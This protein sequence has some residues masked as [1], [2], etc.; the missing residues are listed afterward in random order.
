MLKTAPCLWLLF[1]SSAVSF[2]TS[3]KR[4]LSES[5]NL[6]PFFLSVC[7]CPG[8]LEP[9]LNRSKFTWKPGSGYIQRKQCVDGARTARW[10][11]R[12]NVCVLFGSEG[13]PVTFKAL[14]VF[15]P[16]LV[17]RHCE[18]TL[19]FIESFWS[20]HVANVTK[21]TFFFLLLSEASLHL[22]PKSHFF[23]T[24]FKLTG[25]KTAQTTHVAC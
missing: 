2:S 18:A 6:A 17:R 9:A 22:S 11:T 25:E 10:N 14:S 8:I 15:N 19:D 7:V 20:C 23:C 3:S 21:E 1:H 24:E 5:D 13:H 12:N 4:Q 16:F